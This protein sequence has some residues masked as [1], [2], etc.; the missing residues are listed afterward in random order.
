MLWQSLMTS[1]WH[2][3]RRQTHK[4][5]APVCETEFTFYFFISPLYLILERRCVLV[6]AFLVQNFPEMRTKGWREKKKK[7]KKKRFQQEAF[8]FAPAIENI[9]PKSIVRT[10]LKEDQFYFVEIYFNPSFS[11]R[12]NCP[13]AL[14]RKKKQNKTKQPKKTHVS[15][16]SDNRTVFDW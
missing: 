16:W 2:Q 10:T 15:I 3:L 13:E 4:K 9:I 7:K 12:Y 8:S 6:T 5:L 1:I 11:S 14:R